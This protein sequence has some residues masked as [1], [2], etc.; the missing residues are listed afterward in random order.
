MK[1]LLL[2]LI[3]MFFFTTNNITS[4]AD[5]KASIHEEVY[6]ENLLR[7]QRETYLKNMVKTI[8]FESEI[9]IPEYVDIKYIEYIYDLSNELE[10]STRTIFR[11]I[12]KESRF[13]DTIQSPVGAYGF[14]QLMPETEEFFGNFLGVDSMNFE[15]YN[16]KNIY[17]GVCYLRYLY[18]YWNDR[19][20]SDEYS[21]VL[22]LASY[23]AGKG[24]VRQYK[25]IP[26]FKETIN[27][28]AFI[29]KQH[30]D[31]ILYANLSNEIV[32]NITYRNENLSKNGS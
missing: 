26:P 21:W 15:D 25:G 2:I 7:Y 28:V 5:G 24:R 30:S 19:G 16:Y 9:K 27:Y 18:V 3:I 32:N 12:Y 6:K 13:N 22:A 8:E 14:M 17:I 11:L 4:H 23:N 1:K 31:P 20:N 29:T 10:I